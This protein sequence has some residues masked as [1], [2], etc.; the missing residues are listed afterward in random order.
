MRLH[1]GPQV[2]V[3]GLYLLGFTYVLEV[4]NVN[5]DEEHERGFYWRCCSGQILNN[6]KLLI[7]LCLPHDG[8]EEQTRI[9]FIVT[10]CPP[11][12]IV[13]FV[14][15]APAYC[16]PTIGWYSHCDVTFTDRS[17]FLLAWTNTPPNCSNP[18]DSWNYRP[19]ILPVSVLITHIARS[20]VSH[21]VNPLC[22]IGVRVWF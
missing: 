9:Q 2:S 17:V 12:D 10:F 15:S 7:S 22:R 3:L 5:S 4:H 8:Q 20:L 14:S 6:S 1:R 19:S 18:I 11:I 13:T 21:I 16:P